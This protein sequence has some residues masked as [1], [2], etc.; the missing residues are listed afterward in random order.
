[1]HLESVD[2]SRTIDMQ[3]RAKYN[4]PGA[5]P[6]PFMVN[7]ERTVEVDLAIEEFSPA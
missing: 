7:L 2:V 6:V 1:M 3:K 4:G 5:S